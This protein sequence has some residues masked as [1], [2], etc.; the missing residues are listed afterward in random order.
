MFD[1]T[2]ITQVLRERGYVFES[3]EH[4]ALNTVA[5]AQRFRGS[6]PGAHIKN[7]V[8]KDRRG[9]LYLA[10]LEA[11]RQLHLQKL[12]R[13]I[14]CTQLSFAPESILRDLLGVAPGS[15]SPLALINLQPG[16]IR[17]VMDSTVMADQFI[18]VHPLD[19]RYTLNMRVE[20]LRDFIEWRGFEVTWIDGTD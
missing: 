13:M 15:V 3:I 16:Q 6:L 9:A 4:R 11:S 7:L 2:T 20:D 12:R 1:P 5:D 18:N 19:N 10:V 14:G 8:L 17:L